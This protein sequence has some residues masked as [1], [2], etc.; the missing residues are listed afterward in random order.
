MLRSVDP[1]TGKYHE[2]HPELSPKEVQA[3]LLRARRAF[4]DWRD[5][6]FADRAACLERAAGKLREAASYHAE[7][8]ALEM[9]KARTRRARRG[10]E[11]RLGVRVLRGA[12]REAP[13][14]RVR[15]NGR[16]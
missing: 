5:R 3:A 10:G 2:N 12:R 8:M 15:R 14:A 7:L 6:S 1:T 11:V 16:G 9:G 13:R 4:E